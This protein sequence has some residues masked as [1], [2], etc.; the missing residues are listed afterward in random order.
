VAKSL[1]VLF[2]GNSFTAR[3]DLPGLVARMAA[4]AGDKLE[5]R[6][7]SAGGASLRRHWNAGEAQK[8]IDRGHFDYVVLQEQSTLPIKNADRFKENVRLFHER[9]T[10]AGSRTALYMTWARR[11]SPETQAALT[12]GYTSIAREVGAALIPAGVAWQAFLRL[13]E[14][15]I[16]HDRDG[17]HPTLA[18]S[19]LAACT[20]FAV[21]FDQS[22]ARLHVSLDGL[23]EDDA[24]LLQSV[25]AAVVGTAPE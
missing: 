10:E 7:I 18:G 14:T 24:R 3:N 9:I 15:P 2:I 25:A 22:P 23:P 19:Y 17:S 1:K 11:N 20:A 6:L 5:H 13:H 12:D 21:L 4:A 8:A 16:L